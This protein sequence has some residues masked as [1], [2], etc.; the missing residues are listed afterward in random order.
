MGAQGVNQHG[1]R[2]HGGRAVAAAVVEQDDGAAKLRLDLHG[3]QLVEDGLGDLGRRLARMLIPV[4]GVHLAADDG[5]S[6]L[7]DALD[8]SGLVVGVRLLVDVVGRA[9]VERLDAQ[10]AGEE[11]LREL[12][13]EVKLAVGDFADVG[14][15]VGVVADLMALA[16][17]AL[18]QADIL[19]RLVADQHERALDAL[20]AE[21]IE[22]LRRPLGIGSV[23]EG[24]RDLVGVIAVLL[25]GVSARINVHVLV[26]DELLARRS[27]S[28][29]STSMVRL[30]G[31]GCPVTRIMSP[32]PSLSTS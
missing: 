3:L 31:W 29:V 26:G 2:G 24:E 25:D 16:H 19:L 6:V 17:H 7:L 20:V 11:P 8:R 23:V 21:N 5:V 15:G 18:H 30:P 28:S 12:E 1:Q 27:G 4:V 32:S 9:E 10:L 14:M 13:F 22:N